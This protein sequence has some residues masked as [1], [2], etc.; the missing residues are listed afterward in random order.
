MAVRVL[1]RGQ[2]A[3]VRRYVQAAGLVP[4]VHASAGPLLDIVVPLE[5]G[6]IT[7][8]SRVSRPP[9]VTS[10]LIPLVHAHTGFHATT[11]SSFATQ[12]DHILSLS[13]AE[14]L[15]I[16][17]AAREQATIKFSQSVFTKGWGVSWEGLLNL[18]LRGKEERRLDDEAHERAQ[19]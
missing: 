15:K 9:N 4:L 3:D 16:R 11:A 8:E 12:L 17:K 19:A 7:G 13:S 18:A 14:S 6:Q 1:S 10:W 5:N 2:R